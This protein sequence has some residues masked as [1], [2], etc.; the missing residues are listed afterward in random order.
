MTDYGIFLPG[1]DSPTVVCTK[2]KAEQ[3][4]EKYYQG[5]EILPVKQV[6][7]KWVKK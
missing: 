5:A 4:V 6:D 3:L 1:H 2:E 7:E